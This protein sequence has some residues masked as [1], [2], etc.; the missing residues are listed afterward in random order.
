[1]QNIHILFV[2]LNLSALHIIT[3]PTDISA[4]AP[5]SGVFTCSAKGYGNLTITWHRSNGDLPSKAYSNETI[6]TDITI[7]ILTIPNV[8]SKDVG[9]YYCWVGPTRWHR[10]LIL[11]L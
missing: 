5:F 8:S 7:S 1:M 2:V 6:T 9:K 4:A 10:N 11:Q 3:H